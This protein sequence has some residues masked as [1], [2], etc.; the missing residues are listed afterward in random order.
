[1]GRAELGSDA[2]G[3]LRPSADQRARRRLKKDETKQVAIPCPIEPAAEQSFCQRI[4]TACLPV[5]IED[6][7]GRGNRV[8]ARERRGKDFIVVTVAVIGITFAREFEQIGP[9]SAVELQNAGEARERRR[10]NRN[11]PSLLDPRIPS[12]AEPAELRDLFTPQPGGPPA[13]SG[14]EAD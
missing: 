14:C 7:S 11:V 1:A 12:R 13:V 6:V 4:P 5:A 10:R 3:A 9:F 8:H 2:A